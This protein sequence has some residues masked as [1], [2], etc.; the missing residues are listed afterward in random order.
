MS[1]VLLSI[2]LAMAFA[3]PAPSAESVFSVYRGVALG[4]SVEVVVDHLK[5]EPSEVKILHARPTL[6]Q[7]LTWRPRQF[8]SGTRIEPDSLAEMSLTFHL[9]RLARIAVVYEHDRTEGLTDTD[10]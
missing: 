5:A 4:D 10:L 8:V 3:F 2:A 9:G 7:Q 6:V 1:R